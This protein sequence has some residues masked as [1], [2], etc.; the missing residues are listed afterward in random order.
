[1]PAIRT[2]KANQLA[3][4]I[5]DLTALATR[6]AGLSI[7]ATGSDDRVTIEIAGTSPWQAELHTRSSLS[8]REA[9][10][11]VASEDTPGAHLVVADQIAAGAKDHLAKV[12][13]WGWLDRRSELRLRNGGSTV[14]IRLPPGGLNP[15]ASARMALAA[16]ASDSP[17]RGRAGISYAAALLLGDPSEPPS[18][19]AVARQVGMAP[20]TFSEAVAHLRDAGLIRPTGEPELPDLFW[21]L[22]AVWRPLRANPVATRPVPADLA[23]LSPNAHDLASEGWAQGADEAAL[24]WGAPMFLA[25]S[26]PWVWVPNQVAARQAER[27]LGS[28]TWDGCAGVIA[29]PPTPLV[30]MN[31][32]VAPSTELDWPTPHPLYLALDLAQDPGRGREILE[33]WN[34]PMPVPR[35]WKP[36]E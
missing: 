20:S 18:I 28:A 22:A 1:M 36:P 13:D 26:R 3:L 30:C 7:S 31:R 33:G 14:E 24:A 21:A 5:D 11:L 16:P 12:P 10:A 15:V 2:N 27:A 23:H 6:S 8:P 9:Q 4:A 32:R 19:R 17:I 34:P 35:P 25:G 29:V